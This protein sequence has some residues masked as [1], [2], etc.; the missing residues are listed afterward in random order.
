MVL[1]PPSQ[2]DE[3]RL[4]VLGGMRVSQVLWECG[5]SATSSNV[6]YTSSNSLFSLYLSLPHKP[7]LILAALEGY[8]V[9]MQNYDLSK[10]G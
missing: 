3:E 8:S 9:F 10:D 2:W 5:S 7:D 6:L 1:H 4:R